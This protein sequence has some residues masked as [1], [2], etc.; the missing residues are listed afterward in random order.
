[1]ENSIKRYGM[2]S[3]IPLIVGT[4]VGIGSYFKIGKILKATDGN[5][6]VAIVTWIIAIFVIACSLLIISELI[7]SKDNENTSG[8]FIH[9]V[10]KYSTNNIA[11]LINQYIIFFY[12]PVIIIIEAVVAAQFLFKT[13]LGITNPLFLITSILVIIASF[14]YANYTSVKFGKIFQSS[15]LL[16]KLLPLTL[17]IVLGLVWKPLTDPKHVYLAQSFTYHGNKTFFSGVIAAAP[18]ALFALDGWQW[19]TSIANEVK[20]GVKVLVKSMIIAMIIVSLIYILYSLGGLSVISGKNWANGD[21][22]QPLSIAAAFGKLFTQSIAK[23]IS[24]FIVFAA[25]GGLNAYTI[26]YNRQIHSAAERGWLINSSKFSKL[27]EKSKL[28]VHAGR[29]GTIYTIILWLIICLWG[30]LQPDLFETTRKNFDLTASINVISDVWTVGIFSLIYIPL[31]FWAIKA[32]KSDTEFTFK[33]PNFIFYFCVIIM[34]LGGVFSVYVNI[35]E[36]WI[37]YLIGIIVVVIVYMTT[38][39]EKV[40]INSNK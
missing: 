32:H 8:G 1:M 37:V 34:F 7:S 5:A 24:L 12:T 39:N 29:L 28:P 3:L 31:T 16:I 17:L 13:F 22:G 4:V 2:S 10:E 36:S 40:D 33:L 27:D 18:G 38:P 11:K 19:I 15:S 25:L 6:M 20:G 9:L 26:Y 21:H 23:L 14:M 35:L 30:Y